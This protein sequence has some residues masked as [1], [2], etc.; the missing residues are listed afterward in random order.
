M[1]YKFLFLFVILFNHFGFNQ[2]SIELRSRNLGQYKYKSSLTES[3]YDS[4]SSS[5]TQWYDLL[6]RYS[7]RN[8]KLN[9]F[10]D[11][12]ILG[13]KY[14]SKFDADVG[15]GITRESSFRTGDKGV[16][17]TI[18]LSKDL[19]INLSRFRFNAAMGIKLNYQYQDFSEEE[20]SIFGADGLYNE[21]EKVYIKYPSTFKYGPA[22]EFSLM[23]GIW[24]N[25]S[26]G[27]N[28]NTWLSFVSVNG[29]KSINRYLYDDQREI[30]AESSF[31]FQE[32]SFSFE[33]NREAFYI[34]V[35]Y[36]F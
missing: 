23:Y 5:T 8:K 13:S 32:K 16:Q 24:R 26:I 35:G 28:V 12:G 4:N 36:Q 7:R 21:G 19:P 10:L 11:V 30:K 18:G 27:L 29:E 20:N 15:D 17:L 3:E 25:F 9:V 22:L 2:T 6:L 31:V 34:L 14:D 33:K 1:K